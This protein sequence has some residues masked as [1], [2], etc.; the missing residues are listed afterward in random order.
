M[1]GA[2]SSRGASGADLAPRLA[3]CPVR[4]LSQAHRAIESGRTIGKI[5]IRVAEGW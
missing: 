1:P 3:R 2:S 5:A 4:E